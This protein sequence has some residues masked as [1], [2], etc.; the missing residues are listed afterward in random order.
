M[1][2]GRSRGTARSSQR[3]RRFFGHVLR[4]NRAGQRAQGLF[5]LEQRCFGLDQLGARRMHFA[6]RQVGVD[7]GQFANR[8]A[9]PHIGFQCARGI[10]TTNGQLLGIA[11]RGQRP[12]GVAQ[13]AGQLQAQGGAPAAG[14]IDATARLG[15]ACRPL[16][17]QPKRCRQLDFVF[18]LSLI[19]VEA[20]ANTTEAD[21]A[22][23]R[24]QAGSDI[25]C[26]ASLGLAGLQRRSLGMQPPGLLQRLSQAG[27]RGLNIC[28]ITRQ[29]ENQTGSADEQLP[30]PTTQYHVHASVAGKNTGRAVT[31]NQQR[32][33]GDC[34]GTF[35]AG[36]TGWH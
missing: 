1:G 26:G 13:F 35:H 10:E 34:P 15:F 6:L 17:R 30:L 27:S 12:P 33:V 9:A 22:R 25:L 8:V 29:A 3:G 11:R 19:A 21:R 2:F 14:F 28:R 36:R 20:V 32:V 31:G 18:L 23:L 24:R 4:R 5:R 7:A 16:S